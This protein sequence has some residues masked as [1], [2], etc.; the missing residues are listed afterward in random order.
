MIARG[1]VALLALLLGGCLVQSDAPLSPL[2]ALP[3]ASPLLGTWV[4]AEKD[5][6]SYFHCG[7]EG[8][9]ARVIEVDLLKDGRVKSE[10]Y[11][12]SATTLDGNGYL[13]LELAGKDG[14]K[15]LW[16][17]YRLTG[18]DALTLWSADEKFVGEA[19]KR[20]EISG[21]VEAK[22][23]YPRVLVSADAERL[24]RFVR[25]HD[26]RIFAGK[27]LELR[28]VATPGQ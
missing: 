14:P 21:T 8:A 12:V 1:L 15:Y 24:R 27:P 22:S 17:K 16:M 6:V 28:R 10:S 4:H 5:E 3:A 20:G 23:S 2:V 9:S 11:A 25:E 7:N 13:S 19:V 18:N 26:A